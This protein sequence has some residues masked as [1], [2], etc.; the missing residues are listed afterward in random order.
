MKLT[1]HI[2][3][4]DSGYTS[5][6]DDA[7]TR[8]LALQQL[9][10]EC[11]LIVQTQVMYGKWVRTLRAVDGGKVGYIEFEDDPD[12]DSFTT[13][14]LEEDLFNLV[15]RLRWAR[16]GETV[17][18]L[19]REQA[20]RIEMEGKPQSVLFSNSNDAISVQRMNAGSFGAQRG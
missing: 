20:D 2:D 14:P 7:S 5:L 1:I 4:E 18:S 8:Q 3:E 9:L 11:K 16:S 13:R 19:L 12:R 6:G 17:A 10:M 15:S